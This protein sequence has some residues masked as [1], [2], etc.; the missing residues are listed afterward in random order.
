MPDKNRILIAIPVFNEK[1]YVHHVLDKVLGLHDQLLLVDDG[2]TDGTAEMLSDRARARKDIRLIRHP[3]NR[4]YGQS[5]IDAFQWADRQRYDWVITM[6]C[7]EQHEPERIPDFKR[8]IE[9]GA[10]DVISGSR[11]LQPRQ[12]DD[13]PPT[14]RRSINT[15][16]TA[17]L[18]DLFH[19][20]LTD[21]FC[22]FKAH[23]VSAMKRLKLDIPGY[24]FPLQFWPQVASKQLRVTE[25][26]VRLIYN[27]P[28][29]HFGGLL[30]DA[31]NRLNHYLEVLSCEMNLLGEEDQV[32]R[33]SAIIERKAP[34]AEVCLSCGCED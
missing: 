14:D 16:I 13:L 7:D 15:T 20:N 3:E 24:A 2:S 26:P 5:L 6:D 18:N 31:T 17:I 19:F 21:S 12:D 1:K 32:E 29:R 10:W 23:R 8:A 34:E 30:D 4:G 28:N 22:G 33:L 11:Y 27:D 25:I 9:T